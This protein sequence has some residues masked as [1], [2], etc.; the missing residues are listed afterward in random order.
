[1]LFSKRLGIILLFFCFYIPVFG[2]DSMIS[3]ADTASV[4]PEIGIENS[5]TSEPAP[6]LGYQKTGNDPGFISFSRGVLGLFT[7]IFIAFLIS[8]NKRRINWRLVGMGTLIQLLIGFLILNP[9]Q[10]PFLDWVR[11]GFEFVAKGFT[12]IIGFSDAGV[13]FLFGTFESGQTILDPALLTFA[14]K[15]IPTV[16]FFS[17]LTSVLFYFGF[18]Q[19]VVYVLAWMLKKSMGL[20]GAEA[21][22][23]SGNVFLGQTEAPLLVKP[24]IE[25]MTRSEL[26]CL[27][28]GGMATIAGGV[29]AAYIGFLGGGIKSQELFYAVHLL[30]ASVMSAPAAIVI[31]KILVPETEQFDRDL[32]LSKEKLGSNFLDAI[33]I[34]TTDGLKLAVNVA[35]M[36]LVFTAL[37]AFLN[38]ILQNGIGSISMGGKNLNDVFYNMSGGA[39]SGFNLQALLGYICSPIAWLIG[40]PKEDIL[41][42]GQLLGEKTAINEFYAY[43]QMGKLKN[44]GLFT[45]EKSLIMATYVL[46]GFSNFASIGIQIGGIGALAPGKRSE[47]AALGFRAMIG[48]TLACLMTAS[49]AGMFY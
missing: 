10:I 8:N 36:L 6:Q 49:V 9:F 32:N 31:A 28:S 25:K 45:Y 2:Q 4:L 23:A 16:I 48:G 1:M 38:Y 29:L 21:L 46:C 33:S 11:L 42:V 34:G 24:Y 43:T 39:Y 40:V 5:L 30:T 14:I 20:S 15:V 12:K 44:A 26:L 18:L 37:V 13:V 17:A 7:C 22:A 19:K 27:M 35:A 47:L 41:I 3:A